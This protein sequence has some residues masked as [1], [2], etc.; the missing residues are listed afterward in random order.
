MSNEDSYIHVGKGGTS[1]VGPD[2]TNLYRAIVLRSSIKLY[3]ATG[4]IPTR[5]VTITKML[6]MAGQYTGK[7]YKR[8]QYAEAQA[9]LNVWIETMKSAL[10]ITRED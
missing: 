6:A 3:A 10:P 2:A 7:K 5:G 8:G 9:D 4:M 1:I